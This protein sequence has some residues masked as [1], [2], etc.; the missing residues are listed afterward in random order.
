[1]DLE[2]NCQGLEKETKENLENGEEYVGNPISEF[3]VGQTSFKNRKKT[4]RTH[5][6]IS[7]TRSG[8]V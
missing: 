7:T 4:Y 2:A 1:L 3:D 6:V 8:K 5:V